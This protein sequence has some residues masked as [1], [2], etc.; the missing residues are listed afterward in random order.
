M[1]A[2]TADQV[3]V[4]MSVDISTYI[5]NLRKADAAFTQVMNKLEAEAK[6]TSAAFSTITIPPIPTQPVDKLNQSLGKTN[7]QVGN[8]AAQFNDI[9]VQLAGG[10]SPF[11]IALQ[12]GT[13]INQVL[14]NAGARGAVTALGGALASLV[15]PVS[16]ATIALITLGGV[17]IQALGGIIP[18][19]ESATEAINRHVEAIRGIVQG[20][21][22]AEKAV[23]DYAAATGQ[24]PQG[25]AQFR[26]QDQFREANEEVAKFV[27]F[28]GDI[29]RVLSGS[30]N[31]SDQRLGALL[32]SFRDGEITV[33]QLAEE[34]E[35]IPRVNL[36]PL[37]FMVNGLVDQ[38]TEGALKAAAFANNLVYL[39]GV[40]AE[41]A[42]N[43]DLQF[44]L[45]ADTEKL[46]QAIDAIKGLTPELRTQQQIIAD[47]YDGAIATA[48]TEAARQEL[49]TARDT[50]LAAVAEKEARDA[51]TQA[52]REATS[53]AK[54]SAAE[55]TRER[56]AVLS[57][58]EQLQFEQSLIG[59]SNEQKAI[60]NGL[61]RA[62]AAATAEERAQLEELIASN[63]RQTEALRQTEELY[64]AIK[65]VAEQSLK[66]FLT[67]LRQGASL[68]EA[69]TNVLDNI[70]SKLIDF[71]ANAFI[72]ALLSGAL[73][74]GGGVVAG[75]IPGI[76]GLAG[77]K[78]MGGPVSSNRTY[79]VGERGP[80]LFTPSNAGTITSNYD[81][82]NMG[83]GGAGRVVIELGPGLEASM[84]D[85]S[86]RQ[87]V[88]I[89]KATVPG[90]IGTGAP[91]AVATSQR[92]R[93]I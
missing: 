46:G 50:A 39:S 15:N 54:Q 57:L 93:V 20:Y 17:A 84:L 78:A 90:M 52:A 25:V 72:N 26:L 63:Y 69:F 19:T 32:T 16:I 37:S 3:Q 76:G 51:A 66:G 67:D 75:L 6:T 14:G 45:D 47:T 22:G 74:G 7:L 68:G 82:A 62:G 11:L 89:V 60:A 48:R 61:R 91:Q 23:S 88:S 59:L 41:L 71:G 9:G 43:A 2:V 33:G 31:E 28:A 18:K 35:R 64:N 34:L 8:L 58:I 56:E 77:R 86:A 73:G 38:L 85:K 65:G 29:G 10:Q 49:Q 12:Q 1:A 92:N 87:S 13:Q 21:E 70:L 4:D 44:R 79:L 5:A 42:T 36:G 30:L 80:E 81:L 24:L 53:A 40:A 55:K 27:Q 83:S